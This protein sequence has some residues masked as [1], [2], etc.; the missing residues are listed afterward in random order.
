VQGRTGQG[1]ECLFVTGAGG[2]M[3]R[4]FLRYARERSDLPV[5]AFTRGPAPDLSDL[6][7]VV[8]G[9]LL[10]QSAVLRAMPQG[11]T[12]VHLAFQQNDL[13][14]NATALSHLVTVARQRSAR[15]IVHCSTA[16]VAG[17]TADSWVTEA[18]TCR[19]HTPY[20]RAKLALEEQ[21]RAQTPAE[22]EWVIA[23]PTVVVGPGGRNLAA[24]TRRL[25]SGSP[26][27]AYF[28]SFVFGRRNMNLVSSRN[29]AGA[30]L[31]AATAGREVNHE[32]FL[33]SD[34]PDP[35]NAYAAVES[36]ILDEL[37]MGARLR[38]RVSLPRPVL[39]ALLLA[40]GRRSAPPDR[41][42][43]SAR[44]RAAGYRPAERLEAAVRRF[45]QTFSVGCAKRL[46]RP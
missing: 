35:V 38:P 27:A 29:V 37:G 10:D 44:I 33:V 26:A 36:L 9:D 43:S 8:S 17:R 34:E 45:A 42:Y 19:P 3:G 23:R 14:A 1:A 40:A 18:S 20:E 5:I 16:V 12:V 7:R 39:G 21:L 30:L 11:A 28:R 13:E 25:Q 24:L 22:V 32:V 41:V 2:F 6:A 15:R 46:S 4:E 31:F